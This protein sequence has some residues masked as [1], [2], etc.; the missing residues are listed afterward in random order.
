MKASPLK[1]SLPAL[2]LATVI[3]VPF[4]NK[5]FTIDDTVFLFEARHV[6][7]DPLHPTAF[8]M[9][10]ERVPER[11]S[12]IVPTG[13]VMASLLVPSILAVGAEWMAHAVQLVLLLAAILATVSLALRLGLT[14]LWAAA[15]GM[16]L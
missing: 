3:L 1:Y 11:V 5:A 15:A 16:I 12:L 10:W 4:L 13:P 6:L 14:P 7:T 9:T 8:E 2:L